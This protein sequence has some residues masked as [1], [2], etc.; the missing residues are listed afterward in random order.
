MKKSHQEKQI[1]VPQQN[2]LH[3]FA[4]SFSHHLKPAV[5]SFIPGPGANKGN[6]YFNG[7]AM[8][9]K[10]FAEIYTFII[11]FLCSASSPPPSDGIVRFDLVL[12][13]WKLMWFCIENV[14]FPIYFII[15]CHSPSPRRSSWNRLSSLTSRSR[16]QANPSIPTATARNGFDPLTNNLSSYTR[17]H[18]C[19]ALRYRGFHFKC[20]WMKIPF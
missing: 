3:S 4:V 8:W 18:G 12:I 2:Y 6:N 11:A 17:L 19:T 1:E 15:F 16:S 20:D 10:I 7:S 13:M 14:S 9:E 5:H